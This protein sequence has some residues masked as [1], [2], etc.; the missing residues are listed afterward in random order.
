[1]VKNNYI[2]KLS[3]PH[4]ICII[5]HMYV[6][7]CSVLTEDSDCSEC[8]WKELLHILMGLFYIQNFQRC[9]DP[10]IKKIVTFSSV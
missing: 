1:M 6:L 4:G 8:S 10:V 9:L 2:M 5:L 3:I 7:L